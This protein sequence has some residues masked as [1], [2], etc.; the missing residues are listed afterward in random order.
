MIKTGTSCKGYTKAKVL[1][2][3]KGSAGIR[4]TIANRLG[5]TWGTANKWANYWPETRE[6]MQHE[7]ESV[8]DLCEGTLFK[9]VQ[10]GD[11][12]SAKWIL[13]TMGKDRGYVE[14]QEIT[15]K[16][17]EPTAAPVFRVS[18]VSAEDKPEKKVKKTNKKTAGRT[19]S[20]AVK[21][22]APPPAPPKIKK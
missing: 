2:A 8:L 15:G 14:R 6:A 22:P 12:G 5:C 16:D 17:G 3:I 11:T 4:T 19:P 18:F 20:K 9:A 10:E 7:K 1:A 21:K 13:S